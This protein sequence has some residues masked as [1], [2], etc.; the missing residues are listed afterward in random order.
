MSLITTKNLFY[1]QLFIGLLK[2]EF[3][4]KI[5]YDLYLLKSKHKNIN[6]TDK[7]TSAGADKVEANINLVSR[8][9][10][11]SLNIVAFIT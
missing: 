7:G 4:V 9:F 8:E 5:G 10:C 6:I 11:P 3:P 1:G 2:N